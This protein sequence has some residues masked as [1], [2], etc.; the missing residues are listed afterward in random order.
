MR[1]Y[2][3]HHGL[4]GI[5]VRPIM[6]LLTV[7]TLWVSSLLCPPTLAQQKMIEGSVLS[8]QQRIIHVLNRLGFG[9][10]P[11]DVASVKR[12]GLENYIE[13]Q[14]HPERLSD[15]AAEAKLKNL[16]TLAL[17]TAELYAKYPNPAE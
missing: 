12:M 1:N 4:S 9:P 11:G 14:L 13:Q 8:E 5:A 2:T 10:R 7:L 15:E 17:T 3:D 16:T 6:A